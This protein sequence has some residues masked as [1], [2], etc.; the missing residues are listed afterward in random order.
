MPQPKF[1]A[2]QY[3][4]FRLWW[5]GQGISNIGSQM[6]IVAINWQIYVITHSAIALGAIGLMRVIPVVLISLFAGSVADAYNRKVINFLAQ[7]TMGILSL[8]L[9]LMSLNHTITPFVIYII[10]IFA[11]VAGTFDTTS[12]QSLIPNLVNKEHLASATSLN[13][14]MRETATIIGP[15][16]TG[17]LIAYLGVSWIYIVNALSFA[18]VLLALVF[19][20]TPGTVSGEKA[21]VSAQAML[22]GIRFVK[23]KTLIWSTMLLDFFCTFFAGAMTLLPIFAKDILQVGPQGLGILYAAPS[24]GAI[25]ASYYIA[26]R[27]KLRQQGKILLIAVACYAIGT[28][29]FGFSKM[30]IFSCL[31]LAVVGAGDSISTTIRNSIRQAQTPNNLRGRMVAI[32]MIF[33]MGGPQ[34]GEFEAGLVAAAL[35]APASVILGGLGALLIVT[36]IGITTPILSR[37]DR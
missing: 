21:E 4:D 5:I 36:L 32:N 22:E 37:Y 25:I 3:R 27:H 26:Q 6:Q 8:I 35:G 13:V 2:L 33:F 9:G 31:A 10:T 24:V 15:G 34:L 29:A 1:P 20:N 12:R 28:I 14:V 23:S 17:F 16:I 30:L 11:M 7:V 18:A 19:I